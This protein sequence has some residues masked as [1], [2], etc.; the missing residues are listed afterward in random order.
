LQ[1]KLREAQQAEE[2]IMNQRPSATT[3]VEFEEWLKQSDMMH[4]NRMIIEDVVDYALPL[5]VGISAVG[6]S[7]GYQTMAKKHKIVSP[8]VKAVN[9]N[10][11]NKMGDVADAYHK[12]KNSGAYKGT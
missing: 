10:M 4:H 5:R 3:G 7:N 1:Y 12:A 2:A 8:A 9:K 6:S 11:K